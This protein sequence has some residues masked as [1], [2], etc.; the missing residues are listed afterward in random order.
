MNSVVP[1]TLSEMKLSPPV[2]PVLSQPVTPPP[3]K[4]IQ[5]PPVPFKHK[6]TCQY[7]EDAL[8]TK[9]QAVFLTPKD[10]EEQ[11]AQFKR[12]QGRKLSLRHIRDSKDI[13]NDPVVL[14]YLK[15]QK[16]LVTKDR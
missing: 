10:V 11:D 6:E 7:K 4:P 1:S 5:P 3:T 2:E 12:H 15:E 9:L 16:E 14:N 8:L 13:A